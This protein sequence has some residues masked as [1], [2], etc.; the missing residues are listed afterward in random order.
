MSHF[1]SGERI[2]YDKRCKNR[3]ISNRII[4]VI[5]ADSKLTK[6]T[7]S[8][9]KRSEFYFGYEFF[10]DGRS[11]VSSAPAILSTQLNGNYYGRQKLAT[12]CVDWEKLRPSTQLKDVEGSVAEDVDRYAIS[13]A[14]YFDRHISRSIWVRFIQNEEDFLNKCDSTL[15]LSSEIRRKVLK[16]AGFEYC[17]KR[18]FSNTINDGFGFIVKNPGIEIFAHP[19]GLIVTFRCADDLDWFWEMSMYAKFRG[20]LSNFPRFLD[21]DSGSYEYCLGKTSESNGVLVKYNHVSIG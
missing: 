13:E 15:R 17:G 12:S 14:G 21:P 7:K 1:S 10:V 11:L 5:Y 4:E 16:R 18:L 8:E 19:C 3:N 2:R 9:F 6:L 20:T